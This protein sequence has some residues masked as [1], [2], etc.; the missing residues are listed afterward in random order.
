MLLN[1]QFQ[2]QSEDDR[3]EL[4]DVGHYLSVSAATQ[5]GK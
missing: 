3:T 5:A 1:T 2:Q 4:H